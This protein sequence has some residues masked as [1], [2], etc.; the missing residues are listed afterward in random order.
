MSAILTDQFRILRA[1]EFISSMEDSTNCYYTFLSVPD[2][3][4]VDSNWSTTIPDP[5]DSFDEV[6]S[7]YE[8]VLNSTKILSRPNYWGGYSFKPFYFEFWEGHENRL[9]RRESCNLKNDDWI[10]TLLQP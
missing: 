3:D 10:C 9:N 4:E 1:S 8:E 5:I 6:I 2:T 7:K